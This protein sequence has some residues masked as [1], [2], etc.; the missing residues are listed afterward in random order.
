MPAFSRIAMGLLFAV[1]ASP[2]LAVDAPAA[3]NEAAFSAAQ[4]EFFEMQIRP[5]L[6]ENCQRCHGPEK[7]EGGLRLDSRAGLLGGGDSGPAVVPGN[8]DESLLVQAVR[9]A[10]DGYQMPPP[11]KLA[12]AQIAALERW[13]GEGAA[14]ATAGEAS[15]P[16]DPKVFDLAER[17]K[18]WSFQPVQPVEPPA[19]IDAA[20][21]QTP[22][23]RFILAELE[24]HG[25]RPAAAIDR[26]ALL[27]RVTYDLIGLP[28]TPAELA[29]FTADTSA[30]AIA[31]VV[32]RLLASPR[33]GERWARHWLDLVRYAEGHGHEFDYD[34]PAAYEYRDYCIRALNADVP[35]DQ[36]VCEHIAGDL[37]PQPRRHPTE[38]FNESIIATGFFHLGEATHS[39]VDIL[40]DEAERFDNV[41]DVIGKAFLG[42]T[43]ACARCHDHKFDAISTKDYY[44]LAG[45]LQSSRYQ[46]ASFAG[47]EHNAPLVEEMSRLIDARQEPL[48]RQRQQALSPALEQ[49]PDYL[50]AAAPL[51]RPWGELPEADIAARDEV[52]AAAQASNLDLPALVRWIKQLAQPEQK[53]NDVWFAWSKLSPA[54]PSDF[55]T[56][57]G[58]VR[59]ELRAA[60]SPPANDWTPLAA[61]DGPDYADWF[62]SGEAFGPRPRQPYESFAATSG[63]DFL[64]GMIGGGAAD[65]ARISRRLRGALRSP[66]FSIRHQTIWFRV[67]GTGTINTVVDSHRLI[68]GPLHGS[69]RTRV[70]RQGAPEWIAQNLTDY[71]GHQAYV[72]LLDDGPDGLIVTDVALSNGGAPPDPPNPLVMALVETPEAASAEGL[73]RGYARL[74]AGAVERWGADSSPN[75]QANRAA[76]QLIDW[77]VAHRD[78]LPYEAA[79]TA[80]AELAESR[81]RQAALDAQLADARVCLAMAPGTPEDSPVY[82][83]GKAHKPGDVVPRRFLEAIAGANQPALSDECGRMYLAG[84]L[85]DPANPLVARVL[86]NR[87]WLH[88]FGTGLVPTP[89]NFG[90]QGERPTNPALLDWLAGELIRSQWS[91]KHMHRL[92]VTS[93]VYALAS[94]P[95]P[96]SLAA[97]P[98]N[99]R[100]HYR[101]VARLEAEA[102]RDAMLAL[103]GRLDTTM[104]GPG[105]PV[106]LT[107]FMTGRGRPKESGPLDGAGRRSVY[108]TLRRN[109]LPELLTVFDYP[110]PFTCVGRRDGSNVPAQALMLLNNPFVLQQARRWGERVLNEYPGDASERIR[111]MY[112]AALTREPRPE[113]LAAAQQYLAM[114]QDVTSSDPAEAWAELAHV[115]FNVKEFIYLR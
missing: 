15:S 48:R 67:A 59:E 70:D 34:I 55:A 11:G 36:F 29:D 107:E 45:I 100:W 5:L 101:P 91:L 99:E 51:A 68:F 3:T 112:L 75:P 57:V 97:D 83:R 76:G 18:F 1:S 60:A 103:S 44:A 104:F 53:P 39:P 66:T 20:W 87:L 110:P 85:I 64:P 50:L 16:K 24:A 94:H 2:A 8:A 46:L 41:I 7:Q 10:P 9:Y 92:L 47:P 114:R 80:S 25:L 69:L 65:S 63:D 42:L 90:R 43:I 56:V 30:D 93:Q 84:R 109:F 40:G 37:L 74:F 73:A 38:G 89:D 26:G 98:K 61:F 13:V 77:L 54:A 31:H 22:V 79:T 105:V 96:E 33:Y 88:H 108:L 95:V 14:W 111:A 71:L 4:V 82:I 23:D 72:E 106:Y 21:C 17:A 19:V 28:P 81:S 49:L 27:R 115:L 6:A 32:D 58:Q 12:D 35:Y 86:V 52:Q 62:V 78:W 113:E 102:I